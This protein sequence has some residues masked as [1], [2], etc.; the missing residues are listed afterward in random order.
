MKKFYIL[1]ILAI[2]STL[3]GFSAST[4]KDSVSPS[5]YF[6][7]GSYTGFL[8]AHHRSMGYLIDNYARGAQ[9]RV[10][11]RFNGKDEWEKAFRF[12]SAGLGYMV[13]DVGSPRVFGYGHALFGFLDIS[14]IETKRFSWAYDLGAGLAYVTKKFD[15]NSNPNN[16]VIGSHL[17]AFLLIS[18]GLE[19]QLTKKTTLR[20]DLGLNHFSNGN[21][22]EPNWGLNTFF[23]MVG[24]KQFLHEGKKSKTPIV[25]YQHKKWEAI[26]HIGAAYKEVKPVDG[27]KFF[28]GDIHLTARRRISYTN[29]W[30]GGVDLLYDGSIRKVLK[31]DAGHGYVVHDSVC[32]PSLFENLSPA[33]HGNWSMHFG[34]I[35]FDVQLGFYLFNALNKIYFNRWILEVELTRQLSLLTA[36]KSHLASADYVQ[37]GLIWHLKK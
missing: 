7:A 15:I 36:L 27:T 9:L 37:F 31:H 28:V 20:V 2:L 3:Q 8:Y 32:N 6:Q 4:Q 1:A 16:E 18:S 24:A 35:V 22:T 30:G 13:A 11:W 23:A 34:K 17:N 10:G 5:L 26:L 33:V 29:S 14:I 12:P 25:T 19:Y 21:S